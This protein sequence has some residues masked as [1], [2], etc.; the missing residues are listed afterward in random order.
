MPSRAGIPP[1]RPR[2]HKGT[3]AGTAVDSRRLTA[4][5]TTLCCDCA[6]GVCVARVPPSSNRWSGVGTETERPKRDGSLARMQTCQ[7][8]MPSSLHETMALFPSMTATALAHEFLI[9]TQSVHLLDPSVGI[10][11][12]AAQRQRGQMGGRQFCRRGSALERWSTRVLWD[13]G[14]RHVAAEAARPPLPRPQ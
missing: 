9:C 10:C 8:V 14:C 13:C 2:R 6:P 7:P 4:R 5:E 12:R 1:C 11:S 3:S